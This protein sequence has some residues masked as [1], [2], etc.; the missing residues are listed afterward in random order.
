[1]RPRFLILA[2]TGALL[3]GAGPALAWP[4]TLMQALGRD[5]RRL[6]PRTLAR[7]LGERE[8]EILEE[9]R[10][11]PVPLAERLAA[12][13]NSG[14]LSPETLAEVSARE[15]EA[16]SLIRAHR[17]SEGLVRLGALLRIPADLSDP[18]LSAGPTGYPSGVVREYYAFVEANLS[19]IPVVLDDQ[20]ALS[21]DRRGL[22]GYWEAVLSRSR[23]QSS[24][25]RT[26]LFKDGRV[27]DH[28]R[29]DHRNPVFGVASLSYSRGVTA[30]AATWLAVWREV[31]GDL[32]RM[33]AP[34]MV[35]PRD[36]TPEPA[37]TPDVS[38]PEVAQ[39]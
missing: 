25:I 39:P 32:T 14:R 33:P 7:L 12:D 26:E 37:P 21:L 3:S 1:M 4:E 8:P 19:K 18:V 30:I 6:V 16:V 17:V 5:A 35:L 38:Q 28:H 29:I 34:R 22:P 20:P 13:L 11:F 27:V 31:R 36:D 23:A 10:R 9:V 15:A 2:L 24:V